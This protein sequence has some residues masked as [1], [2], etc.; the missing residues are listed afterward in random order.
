MGGFRGQGRGRHTGMNDDMNR[1]DHLEWA[2]KR[3]L[4]HLPHDP[5][6]AFTSMMTD[7]NKHS[8]LRDHPGREISPASVG[9]AT[10]AKAVRRWIEGLN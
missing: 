6:N 8:E 5:I 3:A 9:R 4:A 10:D 1:K 2:K 7:L